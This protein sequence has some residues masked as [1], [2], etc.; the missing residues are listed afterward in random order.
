MRFG[1]VGLGIRFSLKKGWEMGFGENLGWETRLRSPLQDPLITPAA[2]Q[3][4]S[5]LRDL[6]S[7][8]PRFNVCVWVQL[9]HCVEWFTQKLAIVAAK[10]HGPPCN[11]TRRQLPRRTTDSNEKELGVSKWN[12]SRT[13]GLSWKHFV[14]CVIVPIMIQNK[15]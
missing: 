12:I 13:K 15:Q 1:S 8:S 9:L 3:R 6:L 14:A 5:R 11:W 2:V 10:K 4:Q 7:L